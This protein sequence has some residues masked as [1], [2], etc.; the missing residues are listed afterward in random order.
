MKYEETKHCIKR[1][2]HAFFFRETQQSESIRIV[3]IVVIFDI[4]DDLVLPFYW[5]YVNMYYCV[6]TSNNYHK[7]LV[8]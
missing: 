3:G 4:S 7:N 6:G 1:L 2:L 5:Y 8:T